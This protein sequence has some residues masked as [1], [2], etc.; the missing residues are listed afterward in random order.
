MVDIG[1]LD[2]F[3]YIGDNLDFVVK[4]I[5][6]VINDK[7]K[8]LLLELILDKNKDLLKGEEYEYEYG[9]GYEYGELYEDE[10]EYE[11]YYYG[12]YDLYIWL[13]FVVS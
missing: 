2:L 4:K 12:K 8:I 10:Y 11:Y 5:V 13:D 6:K 7:D 3:L 1:K 9:E